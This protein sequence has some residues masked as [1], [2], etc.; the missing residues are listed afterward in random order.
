MTSQNIK[1]KRF[2][3]PVE[4]TDN[5]TSTGTE[6]DLLDG[7]RRKRRKR[8]ANV[9]DAVAARVTSN[10]PLDNGPGTSTQ[11]HHIR[12]PRDHIRDSTLAPE[13]VLFRRIGAPVRFAEKDIYH[14]HSALRDGGRDVLP[15]SD[16]L[17]A[18]HSYASHFYA[19]LAS[20][21]GGSRG[22]FAAQNIDEQSLDETALLALGIL[23]EEAGREILGRNGD[24]VFTE[25]VEVGEDGELRG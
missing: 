18:L 16:M 13:E 22:E 15:D 25:G 7:G 21:Q 20:P 10:L 11:T 6:G 14:A 23:V 2:T 19:A 17:K 24:L 8:D 3:Y 12:T 5:A 9:Y 1:E 4:E